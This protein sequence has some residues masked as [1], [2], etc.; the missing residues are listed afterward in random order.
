MSKLVSP[1]AV[2]LGVFLVTAT[3]IM[4]T[5]S[6]E[7]DDEQVQKICAKEKNPHCKAVDSSGVGTDSRSYQWSANV[8]IDNDI[9]GVI[10]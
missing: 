4:T 2:L 10:D 5:A 9:A 1:M 8:N 6:A 3:P 7:P